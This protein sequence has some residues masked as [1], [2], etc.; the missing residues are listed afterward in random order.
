[1]VKITKPLGNMKRPS[2]RREENLQSVALSGNARFRTKAW[3][4]DTHNECRKLGG[5]SGL[6]SITAA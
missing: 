2:A 6:V 3:E 5:F 1:M 4:A